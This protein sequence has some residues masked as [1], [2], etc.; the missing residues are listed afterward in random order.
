MARFPH[1]HSLQIATGAYE[2]RAGLSSAICTARAH[3]PG[4]PRLAESGK[5]KETKKAAALRVKEAEEELT[6]DAIPS[7]VVVSTGPAFQL[8]P[9]A[10]TACCSGLSDSRHPACRTCSASW[11]LLQCALCSALL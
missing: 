9:Q 4:A 5:S 3:P 10:R 1:R 7:E 6:L 8:S 2:R 11:H